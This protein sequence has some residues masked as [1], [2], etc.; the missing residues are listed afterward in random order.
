MLGSTDFGGLKNL[1]MIQKTKGKKNINTTET[2][3]TGL[4]YI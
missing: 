1:S 3:V 2:L 4:P